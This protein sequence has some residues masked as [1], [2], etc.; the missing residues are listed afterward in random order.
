MSSSQVTR[1]ECAK[2]LILGATPLALRGAAKQHTIEN[3]ALKFSV[4]L[5]NGALLSRSFTNKLSNET[6][7]LPRRDFLF[8]F[9]GGETVDSTS[10]SG[11]VTRTTADRIELVFS[12][13]SGAMAGLEAKVEY[14]LPAGKAYLRKQ[15]SVRCGSGPAARLVRADLDNW[16]GVRRDWQSLH[17]DRR[18]FGSH[19]IFCDS[20][21]AGVEFVAAFNEYGPDGFVLRSRPGGI[22]V[23]PDWRPL[24][25]TVV[26]CA[27]PRR[28]REAFLRYIDDIRVAP[29][30]LVA[31]YNT[32]WTFYAKDL[33]AERYQALAE[34][35]KRQLHDAHGIFFDVVATD[36]GWALPQS[37]WEMDRRKLPNGFDRVREV[38]E[39]AGGKMGL[40]MSPSA[41]YPN[42]TDYD[43]AKSQGH[44]V[45]EYHL[46]P[47]QR[48]PGISLADPAY[49]E[50]TKTH[51]KQLIQ[52][53]RLEHVKYDGF[54]AFEKQGH[55]D[56][57]PGDDSVEPL[58]SHM[59][60][61]IEASKAANPNLV[62]EPTCINSHVN[63]ISPWIVKHADVIWGNAG[64]DCPPGLGPAPDYREAHTTARE[65]YIFSSLNE[66]WLPQNALQYFDIVHCDDSAGFA[67]H[68]AMAFGRGRFFVPTYV[69][70]KY[71]TADDWRIYA[72]LLRWA[73]KNKD[74]LK[75]TVVLPSRVELGEPYAYAHWL[76]ARG[77]IAVRN[78]SN[79]TR[80]YVLD[81]GRSGAPR[82]LTDAV[83]YTQYP[84]RKGI[85][86]GVT[87][88]S[89]V[90]LRLAPWELVFLEVV[91]RAELR[92][93]VV[94][95]A[96]WYADA[97]EQT[98]ASPDFGVESVRVLEPGGQDSI[99]KTAASPREDFRGGLISRTARTIPENE[100]LKD[101]D[102]PVPTAGFELE[103]DVS[104]PAGASGAK[105]FFLVEFPGRVHHA[106][107]CLI[108]VNGQPAEPSVTSSE[109]HIGQYSASPDSYWKDVL[110]HES[111]WTWY[112][113]EIG[114]GSSRVKFDGM[115][116]DRRCR[117]GLWSWANFDTR[118]RQVSLPV[119]VRMPE[120]PQHNEHIE[121][122]GICI[123]PPAPVLG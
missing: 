8:E 11:K 101:K 44:V 30:R 20:L 31:C 38:V 19:P 59:L 107:T 7:Q 100:W 70:P 114:A 111:V 24:R 4:G 9:D 25:S 40:W 14:H 71:M 47:N 15:I 103:C 98:F 66:V 2:N 117:I 54:I 34:E 29:P 82:E 55:H 49:R 122:H 56:L 108:T 115:A 39:S 110:K 45:L 123:V 27:A 60:E 78:P 57:L 106:S 83:C 13:T 121:R 48:R 28:V 26:G 58:A 37:I 99:T 68:A 62:A 53:S 119:S 5:G 41:V 73:R 102:K 93:P 79:E 94:V 10:L 84:Y 89:T 16:L 105:M 1:R 87:S 17:A 36:E 3:E 96:R 46:R 32:W 116:A 104:V 74:L 81:L 42:S 23:G 92:E 51:L 12:R 76:G 18:P 61:L 120:M 6:A 80:E 67:N 21:W 72:G 43:W 86:A 35:L 118:A 95:G 90:T 112:A 33:S 88:V 69:N 97:G 52:E 65:Y 91:P 85:A 63:Y 75:N 22:Q 113:V 64:G 50:K 77:V 109:G